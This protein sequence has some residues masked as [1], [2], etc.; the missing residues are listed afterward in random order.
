MNDPTQQ[1]D[2]PFAGLVAQQQAPAQQT[3]GDDPSR[4]SCSR[5]A[6]DAAARPARISATRV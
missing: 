4:R 2:D 6:F 3:A 1:L 5:P